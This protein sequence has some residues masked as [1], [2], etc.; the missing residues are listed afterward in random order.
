MVESTAPQETSSTSSGF[1]SLFMLESF[2]RSGVLPWTT[3][4]TVNSTNDANLRD[5]LCQKHGQFVHDYACHLRQ[6]R[7]DPDGVVAVDILGN[8][9]EQ[10]DKSERRLWPSHAQP[11]RTLDNAMES[12]TTETQDSTT[13]FNVHL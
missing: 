6:I 3:E 1:Y 4:A 10:D 13:A 5:A 12:N 7:D 9:H 11:Q 8:V 2:L